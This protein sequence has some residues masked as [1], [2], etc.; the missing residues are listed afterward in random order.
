MSKPSSNRRAGAVNAPVAPAATTNDT[1]NLALG[2]TTS[3]GQTTDLFGTAAS[4]QPPL[5]NVATVEAIAQAEAIPNVSVPIVAASSADAG[6]AVPVAAP[7][8]GTNAVDGDAAATHAE[9][10]GQSDTPATPD[11]VELA[12]S[13]GESG[14][15]QD[16]DSVSAAPKAAG[17]ATATAVTLSAPFTASVGALTIALNNFWSTDVN[18]RDEAYRR[19]LATARVPADLDPVLVVRSGNGWAIIGDP[20]ALIAVKELHKGS[21]DL[22]TIEVPAVEVSG[23]HAA[24]LLHTA[25]VAIGGRLLRNM[26]RARLALLM[27]ETDGLSRSA[28]AEVLQIHGSSA[29]RDLKAARMEREHPAL[30]QILLQ[31]SD[32]PVSY[33][34]ELRAHADDQATPEKA[35][36]G[37]VAAAG[38]L[39]KAGRQF[40]ATEAKA[41]LGVVKP[42]RAEPKP[43]AAAGPRRMLAA[44]GPAREAAVEQAGNAVK[45]T[46]LFPANAVFDEQAAALERWLAATAPIEG[47]S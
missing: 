46:L 20:V 31:P 45:L 1:S 23:S 3:G 30:A 7:T 26:R 14:D 37:I 24:I 33:Y 32:A 25:R 22:D 35:M 29:T 18:P 2:D 43:E 9:A 8:A 28:M 12:D 36:A 10:P 17:H 39:A 21:P 16:P 42:P 13:G 11:A 41:A 40:S 5:S 47:S 15:K 19:I 4:A 6:T 27:C 44:A 38:R 34:T